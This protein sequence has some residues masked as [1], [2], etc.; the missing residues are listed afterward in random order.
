ME[1][2]IYY[3]KK[4]IS[5][6]DFE[7][8]RP[9]FRQNFGVLQPYIDLSVKLVMKEHKYWKKKRAEQEVGRH[10]SIFC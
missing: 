6:I 5:V 9:I 7:S 10:L 2:L 1:K 4:G 8:W 3:K